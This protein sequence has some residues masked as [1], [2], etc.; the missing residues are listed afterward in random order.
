VGRKERWRTG[1]DDARL[2]YSDSTLRV[3]AIRILLEH[4]RWRILTYFLCR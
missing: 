1:G 3:F 4:F 2:I